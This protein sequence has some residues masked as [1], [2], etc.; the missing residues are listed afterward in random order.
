MYGIAHRGDHVNYDEN[1]ISALTAVS[2]TET[3][4]RVTK[5]GAFILMHDARLDRTTNGTG[6]V[7]E[8]RWRYIR[9]LR[10]GPVGGRVPL[11][12]DVLDAA[13]RS[14]TVLNVEVKSYSGTWTK[15]QLARAVQQ[16]RD[17]RMSNRVLL[18]GTAGVGQDL[19]EV[20]RDIRKYWRPSRR[21]AVNASSIEAHKAAAVLIL[22]RQ[23]SRRLVRRANSAGALVW[24]RRGHKPRD[25][26]RDQYW[27][28]IANTGVQGIYTDTPY[29]FDKWCR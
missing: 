9:G 7:A 23:L 28:G 1:T 21:E 14:G 18:G 4:L 8:R 11:F 15:N 12:S 2:H 3:D 17:A 5:D 24:A 27:A 10:T 22:P 13:R 29:A 16:I 26:S 20:A 19:R 25:M 6:Y